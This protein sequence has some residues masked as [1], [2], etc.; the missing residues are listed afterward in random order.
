[1]GMLLFSMVGNCKFER[2]FRHVD[3]RNT[4]VADALDGGF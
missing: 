1:M 3:C 4:V 2:S